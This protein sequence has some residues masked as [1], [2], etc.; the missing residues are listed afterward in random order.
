M[1]SSLERMVVSELEM[2]LLF[3][4]LLTK[5]WPRYLGC[6]AG[7]VIIVVCDRHYTTSFLLH[8]QN[9]RRKDSFQI[10]FEY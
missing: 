5:C 10:S 1:G 6:L 2:A 9:L 3:L 7:K 8:T 4:I